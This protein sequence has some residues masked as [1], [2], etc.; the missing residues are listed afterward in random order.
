MNQLLEDKL[1]QLNNDDYMKKAIEHILITRVEKNKPEVNETDSNEL[2]G[3]KYR[4]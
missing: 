1:K 3:E 4:G 2:L